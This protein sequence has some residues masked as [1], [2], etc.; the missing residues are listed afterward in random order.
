MPLGT[1]YPYGLRDLELKPITSVATETLGTLLDIPAARVFSFTDAEE[2]TTLRGDDKN[3]TTRGKGAT[4]TWE[5]E[6]GGYSADVVK[7]I[8]GGSLTDSGTTPAQKRLL[9]KLATDSRPWFHMEG[10]IISDNGGDVHGI[11]YR[12]RCTSDVKYEW[13][14]G[15]WYLTNCS[16][17]AFPSLAVATIDAL[18]DIIF[19]ETAIAVT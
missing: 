2:Y 17:E 16:G 5:L 3:M 18:Y 6:S 8:V 14:D 1:A 19:N 15:E 4:V 9:R 13:K 11:L 12:C 7:A 10:Q